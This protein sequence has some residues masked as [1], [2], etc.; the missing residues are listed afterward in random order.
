MFRCWYSVPKSF[1]QH[2]IFFAWR[3]MLLG[4]VY[5]I[6]CLSWQPMYFVPVRSVIILQCEDKRLLYVSI[7]KASSCA[8]IFTENLLLFVH[9]FH[10]L[11][12]N[13]RRS[14]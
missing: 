11:V 4:P 5:Q 9:S 13:Q 8:L 3:F 6:R 10:I 7:V 14:C 1:R 2:S 12:D